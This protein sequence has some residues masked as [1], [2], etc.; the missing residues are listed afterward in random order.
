MR[1]SKAKVIMFS[2]VF[3]LLFSTPSLSSVSVERFER[4]FDSPDV[5]EMKEIHNQRIANIESERKQVMDLINK[6][7]SYKNKMSN[8]SASRTLKGEMSEV[9]DEELERYW[10]IHKKLSEI[11]ALLEQKPTLQIK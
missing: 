3:A 8:I 11:R 10:E 1:K 7:S 2:S 6:Y 9:M 5:K 4:I